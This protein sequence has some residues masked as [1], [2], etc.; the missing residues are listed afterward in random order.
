MKIGIV[1]HGAD[2]FTEKTKKKA[3]KTILDIL[4]PVVLLCKDKE[5]VILVSGHSPV[6]GVD[7]YAEDICKK[8]GMPLDLKI[9]RQ[10]IW[11]AEYGYKQRNLD[12][13]RDSDE[14]HVILVDKYPEGYKGMRFNK[15]YHCNTSDHIKSGGCW[16]GKQAGKLGKKVFWHII[17]QEK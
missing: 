10:H 11:D 3:Q 6:G 4:D 5:G 16:T 15:C 13:A 1:G 8:L 7:I 17:K 9:P 14:V 2:K 12:I